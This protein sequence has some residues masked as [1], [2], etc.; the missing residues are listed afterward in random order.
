VIVDVE[1]EPEVLYPPAIPTGS[2]GFTRCKASFR[3]P[4]EELALSAKHFD[5]IL[6]QLSGESEAAVEL[7]SHKLLEILRKCTGNLGWDSQILVFLL[8]QPTEIVGNSRTE[9]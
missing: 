8:P 1:L 3:R 7:I 2:S 4:E 9:A 6:T 5:R